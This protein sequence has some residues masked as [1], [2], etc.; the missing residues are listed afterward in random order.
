[1]LALLTI[2][3]GLLEPASM[4]FTALVPSAAWEGLDSTAALRLSGGCRL[5]SSPTHGLLPSL[6][7]SL[8]KDVTFN[9]K[10]RDIDAA[11]EAKHRLEE[12]QRAE[13]RER[14]EKEIQWE[15]RVSHASAL[16]WFEQWLV[17]ASE[18]CRG[19]PRVPGLLPDNGMGMAWN[20]T[21]LP[22]QALSS[23]CSSFTKMENAG[24]MMNL[25][26]SVLVLWSIRLAT[27][28]IP[29]DQGSRRN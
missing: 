13:A 15:T 24:F 20:K 1:M 28:F 5:A 12:R 17:H 18:G 21:A 23:F 2:S 8:W 4:F 29:G 22:N 6:Y 7:S 11:T 14:K 10:I 9:L 26:W 3:S 27:E 16:L 19:G 25:Y